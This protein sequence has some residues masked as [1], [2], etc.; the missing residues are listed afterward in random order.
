MDKSIETESSEELDWQ[1]L[2][3]GEV[4]ANGSSFFQG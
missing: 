2:A 3:G 1:S 4:T